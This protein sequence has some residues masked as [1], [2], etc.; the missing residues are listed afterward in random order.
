MSK[1]LIGISSILLLPSCQKD[2]NFN[3]IGSN[4]SEQLFIEGILYPGKTP[5]I[6]LSRS[7]PFFNEK[8]SPQ[9]IFARDA[10]VELTGSYTL[11]E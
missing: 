11:S 4:Y 1:I 6:Y 3:E 5:K 9:E 8:V 7:L 10:L 2:I